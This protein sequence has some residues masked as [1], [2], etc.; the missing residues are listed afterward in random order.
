MV[1]KIHDVGVVHRDLE[2]N[3]NL[4]HVVSLSNTPS[5]KHEI[6]IIDFDIA[7]QNHVCAA[8]DIMLND[9]QPCRPE[10]GCMELYNIAVL[11]DVWIPCT[12]HHHVQC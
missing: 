9:F 1:K 4:K 3:L 6:R 11:L 2:E 8:K 5:D 10:F 7:E 12:F